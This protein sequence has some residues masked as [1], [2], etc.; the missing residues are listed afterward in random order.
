MIVLRT[1]P[2]SI[3]VE[4]GSAFTFSGGPTSNKSSI[5]QSSTVT[6]LDARSRV[7]ADTA[8]GSSTGLARRVMVVAAT[9]A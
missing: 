8:F 4:A 6:I 2:L 3:F 7:S 1:Q 9:L 5:P